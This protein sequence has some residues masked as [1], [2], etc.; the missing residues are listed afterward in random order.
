MSGASAGGLWGWRRGDSEQ[1]WCR[2]GSCEVGI[3]ER[4][5]RVSAGGAV[6]LA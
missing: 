6:G 1:G 4:A 3:G 2:G 5:S